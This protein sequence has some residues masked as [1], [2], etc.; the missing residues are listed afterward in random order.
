MIPM[1][2]NITVEQFCEVIDVLQPCTDDYLFIYDVNDD[3]YYISPHALSRFALPSQCFHDVLNAHS[4]FVYPPDIETLQTDLSEIIS[5]KKDFHNLEYRW[6]D[7]EGNPVWI[8]CRGRITTA[9]NG[10]SIMVGCINEIG[11]S[12]K[13]DN[14]SGLLGISSL[15]DFLHEFYPF[16]P[17]GYLLRLGLDDF[18]EINEKLG[19]EYGDMVLQK[20]AECISD[21]ICPGQKL[22]RLVADEFLVLDY[23]AGSKQAA[24]SQYK[25]I[26]KRID[27]FV[28]ENHY[29]AVF[30]ISGGILE[31]KEIGDGSFSDV[32]KLSEF[33]L[34]EA[35][36]QGKNRYY[37]FTEADYEKFLTRKKLTQVIRQAVTNNFEGFEA[38]Y[39]PLFHSNSNTL[40]GAETLMRFSAEP[41]GLV[42]PAEFIPILE[43]TG[44]IIPAGRWI[45]HQALNTCKQIQQY[46][47]DFR[48]SINVSYIQLLKSSILTEAALA[49]KK[50]DLQPSSVILELTESGLLESD[51][52]FSDLWQKLKELGVH[53]ALDDFGTGYSNFRYLYEF[54]P[55]I[56]KIDRSFT[57]KALE[58]EYEYNLL[59]LMS[60]MVHNMDLKICIEGI[61][62][63]SELIEI[64]KVAPDYCQGYYF[65]HPV[66][67]DEFIEKFV[68]PA[69][70]Q[71]AAES[72]L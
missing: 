59:S 28:E 69:M 71:Q 21:C 1:F 27:N 16:F 44:L 25:E 24:I 58:N 10:H 26:R 55:D 36:R 38:Y 35:K 23:Q 31:C 66:P 14:V 70:E 63:T 56:I 20:T 43:E 54:R 8:N 51:S 18:K 52:R 68:N 67:Y 64:K 57:A 6:K 22:Y 5:G 11:K 72:P 37:L 62:N 19:I 32:M 2:P 41:Y 7:L 13:A 15:K 30:T 50:Y 65:G 17:N 40:Y 12:Q 39:Q 29:N 48:I 3:Y 53:F 34:N 60:N 46:I 33:S 49:I 4:K 47:P 61:E 42:S 9:D 45:L